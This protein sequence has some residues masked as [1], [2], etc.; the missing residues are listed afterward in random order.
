MGV[1]HIERNHYEVSD[2]AASM[3]E[4][5]CGEKAILF[6]NGDT[7][8]P[9]FDFVFPSAASKATCRPC[10]K[11]MAGGVTRKQESIAV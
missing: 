4:A 6:P 3:T 5:F 8:P 11:A 7:D 10:K 9:G 2:S 1:I